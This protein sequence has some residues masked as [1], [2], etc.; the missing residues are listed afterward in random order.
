MLA[1]G[2]QA[3][4]FTWGVASI[5][6]SGTLPISF[7]SEK[8]YIGY[9]IAIMIGS[10]LPDIDS[11]N[12]KLGKYTY[13]I[14]LLLVMGL[15]GFYYVDAERFWSWINDEVIFLLALI[16]PVFFVLSS[17]RTWTHSL[18]F[19]GLL[20]FYF[21]ILSIWFTI[22]IYLQVGCGLGVLS[23]I[24]GDYLTKRGVPLFYPFKHKYYRFL[25]SF[26]TGSIAEKVIVISLVFTNVWLL[27]G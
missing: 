26:R 12:S 22:P 27:V 15:I 5:T 7:Q 13:P 14:A 18:L 3:M 9:F 6:I 23:H 24:F 10:L 11:M 8:E 21:H 2:H 4:G 19:V 16:I 20:G 17:H 25:F 1:S